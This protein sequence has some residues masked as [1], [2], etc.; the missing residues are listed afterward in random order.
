MRRLHTQSVCQNT[1]LRKDALFQAV[2][3]L[4][5]KHTPLTNF[6]MKQKLFPPEV[7]LL[8][9]PILMGT[10]SCSSPSGKSLW[11]I[12]HCQSLLCEWDTEVVAHVEGSLEFAAYSGTFFLPHPSS[13]GDPMCFTV[14][15]AYQNR[16]NEDYVPSG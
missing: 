15:N 7:S 16:T 10:V 5:P 13:E 12:H 11:K 3:L 2:Y 4:F 9:F 14:V 6:E 1:L 8:V